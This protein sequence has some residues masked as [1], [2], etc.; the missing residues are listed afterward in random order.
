MARRA[1]KSTPTRKER[2][3]S[4][5]S[6]IQLAGCLFN[7][8]L[9][10]D[11]G[12]GVGAQNLYEVQAGLRGRDV[13]RGLLLARAFGFGA[14]ALA[15]VIE[16]GNT[17]HVGIFNCNRGKAVGRVWVPA[18]VAIELAQHGLVGA[19]MTHAVIVV[20]QLVSE[21]SRGEFR[22]PRAAERGGLP[23]PLGGNVIAAVGAHGRARS[24]NAV[25]YRNPTHDGLVGRAA[26]PV[27]SFFHLAP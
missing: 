11:F 5:L 8:Q 22:S 15:E 21:L 9:F 1:G 12:S 24:R 25:Q 4:L 10:V 6:K 18:D 26:R 19:G 23:A 2:I 7:H 16:Y 13:E 17:V 20:A 27:R 14:D 3:A